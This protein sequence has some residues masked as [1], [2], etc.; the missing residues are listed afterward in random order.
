MILLTYKYGMFLFICHFKFLSPMFL[1]CM[2]FDAIV[3]YLKTNF[4]DFLYLSIFLS[5]IFTLISISF[6]LH[7]LI[8]FGFSF[9]RFLTWKL[10]T[11]IFRLFLFCKHLRP[12]QILLRTSLA[13]SHNVYM[14]CLYSILKIF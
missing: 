6:I 3:L 9:Y 11:L 14:L 5:L 8:L 13:V 2:F 4:I 12:L 7:I 10:G 1:S